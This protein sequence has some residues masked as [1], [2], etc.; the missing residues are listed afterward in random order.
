MRRDLPARLYDARNKRTH[1][2]TFAI[3]DC[4]LRVT[5]NGARK[6]HKISPYQNIESYSTALAST[7]GN[8]SVGPHCFGK[9]RLL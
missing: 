5:E 1:S 2:G 4:L 6:S 3:C 9:V 7:L 8:T